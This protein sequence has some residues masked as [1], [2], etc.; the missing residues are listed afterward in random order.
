MQTKDERNQNLRKDFSQH[1][2][3]LEKKL[4]EATSLHSKFNFLIKYDN[5]GQGI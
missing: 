1:L 2:I 4:R 5:E 3:R